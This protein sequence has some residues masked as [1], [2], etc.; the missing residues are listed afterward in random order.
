MQLSAQA[1]P[2][3]TPGSI[4]ISFND[5]RD[6]EVMYLGLNSNSD[7][8]SAYFAGSRW[9]SA[10]MGGQGKTWRAETYSWGRFSASR[11]DFEEIFVW[12]CNDSWIEV[13][14]AVTMI[15]TDGDFQIDTTHPPIPDYTKTRPW[16]PAFDLPLFSVQKQDSNALPEASY[17]ESMLNLEDEFRSLVTVVKSLTLEDLGDP[18]RD[19]YVVKMLNNNMSLLMA[20]LANIESRLALNE[21]S[22]SDPY[23]PGELKPIEITLIDHSRRRAV[24]NAIITYVLVSIICLLVLVNTWALISACVSHLLPGKGQH[25]LLL[26]LELKGLAPEGFNALATMES[27]LHGS[28]YL[29][30]VPHDA[31]ALPPRELQEHIAGKHFRMGWFLNRQ[32][33]ERVFTVG[34]LG[35]DDFDFS[36]IQE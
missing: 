3:A 22:V 19:A 6:P 7:E 36:G 15:E 1:P 27:R 29:D 23:D 25:G 21:T 35:D 24:Q 10:S 4:E 11:T 17:P 33:E 32:T 13:P 8:L 34:I 20:Q 31:F 18:K 5:A 9:D 16:T 30:H 26:D 2:N 14:T 12:W 28:N